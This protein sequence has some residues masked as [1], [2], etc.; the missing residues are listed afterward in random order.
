MTD[1]RCQFPMPIEI[2]FRSGVDVRTVQ[3]PL[4]HSEVQ[5]TARHLHSD[6]RPKQTAVDRLRSLM[7]ALAQGEAG[8]D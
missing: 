4:G 5:T 3:E 7:E 8:H 2:L 6:T 1:S